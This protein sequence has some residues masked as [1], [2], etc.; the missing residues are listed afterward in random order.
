L[1]L[2]KNRAGILMNKEINSKIY[3]IL[4]SGIPGVESLAELALNMRWSWNHEA[5]E[6][7]QQLDPALWELTHNPWIVLQTVSRDQLERQLASPAF[8]EKINELLKLKEQLTTD[9][10]WFQQAHPNSSLSCI[11][12]FSMEYMLSEAL[13]IYVGGLG[14]VAGDQLKSAS[15]LDVP[16]VAIGLLYGQGYFRQ[17]I[18][19]DGFQ[20]A[21]FPYNDPGQLPISPLRLPNGEWLRIKISLPGYPIW[22]RTW[23]VQVGK[24]KL[25]LLDSNDAANL[26]VYRGITNEIYGGGPDTRIKQEMLLGIGGW[27][28]LQALG[29]K[30]EVCH[31]NEGHAAFLIFERA[32]DFMKETGTSFEEALA[33]TRAGNHFTTHTAVA[34]GFDHFSPALMEQYF[35]TYAKDELN[36]SFGELMA[37]GRQDA[38]NLSESFNMAY[39]A[40]HGSGSVNGVSS[41]H[42]TVSRHLFQPLF[43]RW[44]TLE[45]PIGSI[46]N[47]V[48]M[49]SW[50]SEFA[51]KLWTDACGKD[52]WKGELKTLQDNIYKVEDE[53]L[54]E[55]RTA[56]RNS[57][58]DFMRKR[59]EMQLLVSGE[60][61]MTDVAKNIFDPNVLTLGFA[62]RF[63]PY[64]RPT[65]LLHDEERFIRILTNHERPVQ[66]VI[67]GKAP[68][69]DESSKALIRKWVLFIRKHN[70][71]KHVV[72]MSDY[73]ILLTENMVQ[74][75]DVW[76][77]TPRRP[78]EAC[79][80][81]GMKVLVNG[82]LNFSE[83]DGW[84]D[85]AYTPEVGWA[86]GDEQEHGD[87]SDWDTAEAESLYNL[88]ESQV[89]PE[90]YDRNKNGIPERWIQRMRKSMATLTPQFSANRTVREYTE[91]Y[92]L[93][94]A[95]NYLKR[96][97]GKGALGLK[98]INDQHALQNK[99]NEIKIGEIKTEIIEN[100]YSFAVEVNMN[101]IDPNKILV[102]LYAD[103]KENNKPELIKMNADSSNKGNEL[104]KANVITTRP[105]RDYTIRIIPN[106]EDISVPLENNLILWQH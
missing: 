4:P 7:W 73:D 37:L 41:L 69:Y 68:P 89:V 82:G 99:W 15:D 102:Q 47:G 42:G 61:G 30:P 98:I 52:R 81:S 26:P 10:G 95:E 35:G 29:I 55:M 84:W 88:L 65:L 60:T 34:A 38:N 11:A 57:F 56:S 50:D 100:G 77:N 97:A 86:L 23:Q 96:A 18:D 75:V 103:G 66:L 32:R 19:K 39:L 78:W 5:D 94:A 21:L 105:V 16:V 92:Y 59:F 33:V 85:E 25:Y 58:V 3:G 9:Q 80:T 76:L 93:P 27:K 48:H 51:D 79:G 8:S 67:A 104:Y 53:K 31:M 54:W 90:F 6:L 36:I 64:K 49:P 46:T 71:Y 40:I 22:L 1:A 13:P 12:Y 87:N 70:L 91:K 106:H 74:G 20:V 72:F 14:N 44:P 2:V 45:I 24:L 43:E 101:S 28:L 63:V 17:E 83:L 62:R